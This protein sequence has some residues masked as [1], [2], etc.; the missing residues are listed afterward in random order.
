[1]RCLALAQGWLD[2]EGPVTFAMGSQAPAMI[3][4][5][6]AEHMDTAM[7]TA[8][9][10]SL[11][12]AAETIQLARQLNAKWVVVDGYHFREDFQEALHNAG[13]AL[14]VLDDFGH[15]AA[16]HADLV[17]NQNINASETFYTRRAGHTRMLLG[18]P[19]VL[20]RREFRRWQSWRRTT[21]DRAQRLLITMGGSDPANVTADVLG[22]LTATTFADLAVDVVLGGLNPHYDQLLELAASFH[23]TVEVH[24]D[25]QDMSPLI[26]RADMAIIAAG[27]TLWELFF[28][29]CPT[30]ICARNE[31]QQE[32]FHD[33]QRREALLYLG[34]EQPLDKPGLARSL[35]ELAGDGARRRRMA[36]VGNLLVDGRG[37]ARVLEAMRSHGEIGSEGR[38]Q[39]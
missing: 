18:L 5:M 37:V 25:V 1:M 15:S 28:L 27:S 35:Q 8:A 4:K 6:A 22:V 24:R 3:A 29:G 10:G 12:D 26:V 9:A 16:Y 20:L 33:L 39:S 19:Y 2:E 11:A 17:L 38:R 14:L 7:I 31:L 21:P 13:L 34:F 23:R 32:I 36:E 30:M